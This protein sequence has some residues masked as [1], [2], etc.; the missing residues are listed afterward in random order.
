MAAPRVDLA[1]EVGQ[2][3]PLISRD[4][5]KPVPEFILEADAGLVAGAYTQD[6]LERA[7]PAK[8]LQRC[9]HCGKLHIFKFTDAC[10]KP[11]R[12]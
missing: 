12:H 11:T 6:S 1:D 2:R 5:L 4:F 10:L 3:C 9:R 7:N 8:L